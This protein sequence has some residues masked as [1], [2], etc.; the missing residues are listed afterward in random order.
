MPSDY[1]SFR[2]KPS[3]ACTAS[4]GAAPVGGPADADAGIR[5]RVEVFVLALLLLVA[6]IDDGGAIMTPAG[7]DGPPSR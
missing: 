5:L 4:A 6:D 1:S 7:D 3:H 2:G